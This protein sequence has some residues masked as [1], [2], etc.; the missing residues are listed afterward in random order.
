MLA[1]TLAALLAVTPA[2][3]AQTLTTLYSLRPGQLVQRAD[4]NFY[5]TAASGGTGLG[6]VCRATPSG[7]L[8]ALH[9]FTGSDGESPGTGLI[10]GPGGNFYGAVQAYL[11]ASDGAVFK[12]TPAGAFT[13]LYAF[14]SAYAA[15]TISLPLCGHQ[16]EFCSRCVGKFIRFNRQVAILTSDS[17][18]V[19]PPCRTCFSLSRR[20][21]LARGVRQARGTAGPPVTGCSIRLRR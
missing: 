14:S 18:P 17:W 21:Q 3:Q 16:R 7:A 2:A 20:A 5:G 19:T 13:V 12:I 11:P 9:I 1:S 6:A 4:G 15:P 10:P 8:T